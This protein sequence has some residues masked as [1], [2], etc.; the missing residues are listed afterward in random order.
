MAQVPEAS[1]IPSIAPSPAGVPRVGAEMGPTLAG[2]IGKSLGEAGQDVDKLSDAYAAHAVKLQTLTNAADANNRAAQIVQ[3]A[4]GKL[5]QFQLLGLN[6]ARDAYPKFQQDI[7]D[8]FKTGGT[9]LNMPARVQYEDMAR[10]QLLQISGSAGTHAATEARKYISDTAS[11]NIKLAGTQAIASGGTDVA[12]SAFEHALGDN[13]A[14]IDQNEGLKPDDPI[15]QMRMQAER[16]PVYLEVI[17]SRYMNG[18]LHGAEAFY[19]ANKH[20]MSVDG[21]KSADTMLHVARDDD[22]VQQVTQSF[23]D[24]KGIFDPRHPGSQPPGAEGGAAVAE[25]AAGAPASNFV[26]PVSVAPSSKFGPRIAPTKGATSYH[27]GIDYPVPVG[28]PVNAAADGTVILAGVKGGYGNAVEVKHSDGSYTLYG[29]LSSIDVKVGDQVKGGQPI[30]KSGQTG[31]VTGPNLHFGHYD[32]SGKAIDPQ[33]AIKA[34]HIGGGQAHG[35]APAAGGAPAQ[36]SGIPQPP[37]FRPN[38]DPEQMRSDIDTYVSQTI[39]KYFGDNP[40]LAG[41]LVESLRNAATIKIQALQA[42]QEAA[43]NRLEDAL[44]HGSFTDSGQLKKAYKG[45]DTDY[46]LLPPKLSAAVDHDVN[47]AANGYGGYQTPDM[48][49]RALEIEG[50]S[51]SDVPGFLKL[52]LQQENI[53]ASDKKRLGGLQAE[54]RRATAKQTERQ[55][56]LNSYIANPFIS[57][58]IKTNWPDRTGPKYNAF[59]GALLGRVQALNLKPGEKPTAQQLEAIG[60]DLVTSHGG[61]MGQTWLGGQKGYEVPP[62][63]AREIN[64][65][66]KGQYHRDL[67]PAEIS[68]I[69]QYNQNRGP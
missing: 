38:E 57:S 42:A 24:G 3:A 5:D 12:M 19:D 47:L 18:D 48:A 49:N 62:D 27:T 16:D 53:S 58:I 45:A 17:R 6:A 51:G 52:N 23:L 33:I 69:Y 4:Q 43:A 15:V 21:Q 56:T 61:F 60:R 2:V 64:E 13:Q 30:A 37:Q 68:N 26:A 66:F 32:A 11:S 8:L 36:G 46:A 65:Q 59:L 34:G 39:P 20:L 50:M 9:G 35:A 14:I 29:H 25:A 22:V 28:T 41:R 40:Q 7:D 67:S 63:A 1:E 31:T 55:T 54:L 10:R 44:N